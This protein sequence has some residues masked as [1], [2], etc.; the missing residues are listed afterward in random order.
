MNLGIEHQWLL[1]PFK[2]DSMKHYVPPDERI[3]HH[4]RSSFATKKKSE[5]DQPSFPTLN[6]KEIQRTEVHVKLS[7]NITSSLALKVLCLRKPLILGKPV[8]LSLHLEKSS[9]K[10]RIWETLSVGWAQRS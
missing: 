3:R 8:G 9:G 2:K 10:P 1:T 6:L 4:L 5:S 7:M